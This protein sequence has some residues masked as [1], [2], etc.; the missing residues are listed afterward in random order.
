MNRRYDYKAEKQEEIITDENKKKKVFY[1]CHRIPLVLDISPVVMSPNYRG[2][3]LLRARTKK[4]HTS[5]TQWNVL[6]KRDSSLRNTTVR[7][8]KEEKSIHRMLNEAST[9]SELRIRI[10]GVSS[11][12]LLGDRA[13]TSNYIGPVSPEEEEENC[14]NAL[15]SKGHR[16]D[17]LPTNLA[18]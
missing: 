15:R 17:N 4:H 9:I 16:P 5:W 2:Y 11:T 3:D 8:L 13:T 10:L 18:N 6:I 1:I 14:E 12:R 7:K